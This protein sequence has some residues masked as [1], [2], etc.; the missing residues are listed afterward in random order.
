MASVLIVYGSSY[1]QTA[2]IAQRLA[3]RLTTG[4]NRVTVWKGDALPPSPR[5]DAFDAYV[6]AASVLFG[7][8]QPYVRDFVRRNVGRLNAFP[9]AFVSVCG[10]LA[11]NWK[12]GEDEARKY[13]AS[14]LAQ[15]GWRPGVS[16]SFAGGLPYTHYGIVT[17]L[18]MKS[19]S[20]MTGRPTDTSRD[21]EFTDW[22]E[23]DR[24]AGQLTG[25]LAVPAVRAG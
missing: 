18:I 8:H 12:P 6:V 19:I 3:D 20:R 25:L 2:K 13:I 11:G 22:E 14:F 9:S 4:G 1:G 17:R 7:K 21:W 5:V 10:A 24:F 15:T 16:R 23:V